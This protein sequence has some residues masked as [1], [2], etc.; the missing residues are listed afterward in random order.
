M[1]LRDQLNDIA[2]HID[3]VKPTLQHNEKIFEV[4]QGQLLEQVLAD[5]C[6]Q[7]SSQSYE[8]VKHRVAPI[9]VLRKITK[10]RSKIYSTPP[11][12]KI[13][14][15]TGSEKDELL[16]QFYEEMYDIDVMMGQLANPFFNLFNWTNLEFFVSDR[17]PQLRINP[18]DRVIPWGDDPMNKSKASVFIKPMGMTDAIQ[19]TKDDD[20]HMAEIYWVYSDEEFLI[21][22]SD[23]QVREDLMMKVGQEAGVNEIGVV[24][25]IHVNRNRYELI[26]SADSD[27]LTMTKLIP[28]LLS[29]MNIAIMFQA[30]SVIYGV[31]VDFEN[32]SMAPN[33]LWKL[34]T[35]PQ[36]DK[37]PEVG[38]LKPEVSVDDVMN[39]IVQ[40]L[41][42]W[43]DSM[44][45]KPGSI[46]KLTR[47][48]LASGVSKMIDEA[49]TSDDR[50]DQIPFFREAESRLWEFTINHF[51]PYLVKNDLID[52]N[53]LFT[54]GARVITEF[55]DPKP[56]V[57]RGEQ[58]KETKEEFDAG[59][60]DR[61][62]AI[63]R[64]NP[65]LDDD[66]IDSIMNDIRA[67]RTVTVEE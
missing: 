26:P 59:F 3:R 62:R 46:G 19:A 40:L 4:W 37:K 17:R 63:Q 2:T 10:K 41:A 44:G 42:M 43:L 6:R 18:S 38:V 29:D 13:M 15:G 39:Y 34:K 22:Q 49:D 52:E 58:I 16:L 33:A 20:V 14:E 25:F 31:D 23:G 66:E 56:V 8:Q 27:T 50:R 54:Q 32:I 7:L 21:I 5:L 51:H 9:N 1:A 48:N 36:T 64:L 60:I 35:D 28:I 53:T 30:F 61:R 47:E 24:P 45:I 57:D 67:E 12:R 55:E 11:R 65:K